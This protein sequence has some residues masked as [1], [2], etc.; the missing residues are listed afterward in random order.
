MK[1]VK[2]TLGKDGALR[3]EAEGYKGGSCQEATAFL[4][5]LYGDKATEVLKSSYYEEDNETICNE[6]GLPSGWCG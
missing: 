3:V 5:K 6:N 4:E 2:I 1:T